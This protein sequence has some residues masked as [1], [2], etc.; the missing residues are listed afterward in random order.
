MR[1]HFYSIVKVNVRAMQY[2]VTQRIIWLLWSPLTH[3]RTKFD[4]KSAFLKDK[5]IITLLF[6]SS[7]VNKS[8]EKTQNNND[9]VYLL[10]FACFPS[11]PVVVGHKLIYCNKDVNP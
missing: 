8:H 4:V 3:L 1:P 5:A 9:L 2:V 10:I 7:L 11:L 6:C